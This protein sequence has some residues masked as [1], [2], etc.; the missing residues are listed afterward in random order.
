MLERK[1]VFSLLA[2]VVLK[3]P[4]RR[5][6]AFGGNL[7]R[8]TLKLVL[9]Y[10]ALLAVVV[11]FHCAHAA[12][13]TAQVTV[14]RVNLAGGENSQVFSGFYYHSKWFRGDW[15]R[16]SSDLREYADLRRAAVERIEA[17]SLATF[18]PW[19][20]QPTAPLKVAERIAAWDALHPLVIGYVVIDGKAYLT[21][22]SWRAKDSKKSA[23]TVAF[24][25]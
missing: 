10:L 18:E 16:A 1:R 3:Y 4:V 11:C 14:E 21:R 9:V 13:V 22:V 17:S 2:P 23:A 15:K 6:W 5:G 12:D 8:S 7:N 19:M 24:L 20:G 25:R